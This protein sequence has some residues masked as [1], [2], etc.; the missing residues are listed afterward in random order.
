[1]KRSRPIEILTTAQAMDQIGATSS[2]RRCIDAASFSTSVQRTSLIRRSSIYCCVS[3]TP[4]AAW[5]RE[6][7]GVGIAHHDWACSAYS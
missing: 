3:N 5:G 6:Q 1:M 4:S 2:F 7:D